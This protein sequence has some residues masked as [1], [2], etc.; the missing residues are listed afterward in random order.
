MKTCW[1]AGCCSSCPVAWLITYWVGCEVGTE[2]GGMESGMAMGCPREV[3]YCTPCFASC[4]GAC[5]HPSL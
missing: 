2:M 1:G 5:G 3:L 4:R